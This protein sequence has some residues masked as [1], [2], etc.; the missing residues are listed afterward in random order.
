[1]S[2]LTVMSLPADRPGLLKKIGVCATRQIRLVARLVMNDLIDYLISKSKTKRAVML[3]RRHPPPPPEPAAADVLIEAWPAVAVALLVCF[4]TWWRC[5]RRK[6]PPTGLVRPPLAPGAVYGIGHALRYK[7]DP[8]AF[9]SSACQTVGP[10]F[11]LNLAGKRMVVVGSHQTIIKQVATASEKTL[12]ARQAVAEIGFQETLG[13][14]NV[15]VGTDIHKRWIKEAYGPHGPGL[16]GEI[17]PLW[18]AL[19]RA[20]EVERT[21]P[22]RASDM[23]ALARAT[24]LRCQMERFLGGPV[25]QAAGGGAFIDAFMTFQDGI[26]DATAK[27]AVLPRV[28]ALP[29]VL[30]PVARTRRR[31]TARLAA[32]IRQAEHGVDPVA[33]GSWLHAMLLPG[34]QRRPREEIAE[35]AIGLLFAS[36]KNPSIGAAQ[37]LC[38]LLGLGASHPTVR[39]VRI[40]AARLAASPGAEVLASCHALQRCVLETLRLCAHAIGAVRTV[41]SESGFVLDSRFWVAPGETIALA[42]VAVHRSPEVWGAEATSFDPARLVYGAEGVAATTPDEY[43]YTTF[44]QGLHKCPG[45]RLALLTMEL[46]VAMLLAKGAVLEGPMPPVS[47]ERATLAQR[48]GPVAVQLAGP[49]VG[50]PK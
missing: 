50:V 17:G 43:E 38:T 4:F 5:A 26:E 36:H 13:S 34:S 3:G 10:V 18:T 2:K 23:F 24:V 11:R 42:H 19:E 28:L 22:R 8:A 15:F 16:S 30:W 9:L 25:L 41:V 49:G 46:L 39:A 31:L 47:F 14:L 32:A 12:S 29:L 1:M 20:L 40:E 27:A 21:V 48:D 37:T 35:L 33:L 45:E 7:T 44:S 6:H